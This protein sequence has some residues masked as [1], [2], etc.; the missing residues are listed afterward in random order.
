MYKTINELSAFVKKIIDSHW[1]L[2]MTEEEMIANISSI[3]SDI[4]NRELA[5]RGASFSPTFE[6][7]L[8]TKRS[9]LLKS[10]LVKIDSNK[11]KF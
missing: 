9:L 4:H 3:F 1:S 6:R 11:Y 8:G 2:E 10:L 7:K 5:F